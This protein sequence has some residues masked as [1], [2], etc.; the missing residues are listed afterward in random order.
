MLTQRAVQVELGER[1]FW[2]Y[3]IYDL[4]T[5]H[6]RGMRTDLPGVTNEVLC[7]KI[8]GVDVGY[9]TAA[10]AATYAEATPTEL[11]TEGFWGDYDESGWL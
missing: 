7:W 4:A 5:I 1:I 9:W 3:D 8:T 11:T 10:D 2:T 6:V